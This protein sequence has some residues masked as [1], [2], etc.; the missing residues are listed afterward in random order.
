MKVD[1]DKKLHEKALLSKGFRK[2]IEKA[3]FRNNIFL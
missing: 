3:F 1:T 2:H